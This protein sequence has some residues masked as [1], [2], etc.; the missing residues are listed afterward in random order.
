MKG[1]KC[2][3]SD[4]KQNDIDLISPLIK[5]FTDYKIRTRGSLNYP[6]FNGHDVAKTLNDEKNFARATSS[7]T[8]KYKIYITVEGHQRPTPYLTEKGIYKYLLQSNRPE[9]ENFHEYIFDLLIEQRLSEFSDM[10]LKYK[11]IKHKNNWDL[12]STDQ[13]EN[14]MNF[15]CQDYKEINNIDPK[16]LPDYENVKNKTIIP[17]RNKNYKLAHEQFNGLLRVYNV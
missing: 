5:L 11:I 1:N 10:R 9:A 7:Y 17:Y 4:K 12:G 15:L 6:L 14:F 13:F 2:D 3:K 8:D 16:T